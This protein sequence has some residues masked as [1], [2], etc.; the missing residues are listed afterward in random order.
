[1]FC[2][3]KQKTAYEM[4]ISYW[5]SDVCSSDL[6]PGQQESRKLADRRIHDGK[7]RQ[8]IE[9]R[10]QQ[11]GEAKG[12]AAHPVEQGFHQAHPVDPVQP[13][14]RKQ[15]VGAAHD[16]HSADAPADALGATF[17]DSLRRE[18]KAE[19]FVQLGGHEAMPI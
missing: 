2:F 14:A 11:T 1:M 7:A 16:L 3:F 10:H 5:S 4:R 13:L 18:A 15:A 17:A 9:D 19:L 8:P 12:K 6:D